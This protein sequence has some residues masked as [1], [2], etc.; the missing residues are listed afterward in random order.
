MTTEYDI[1]SAAKYLG[2]TTAYIRLLVRTKVLPSTRKPISEGS[3]VTKHT[4][5]QKQVDAIKNR[6]NRRILRTD[7]RRKYISFMREDEYLRVLNLLKENDLVEV[8]QLIK[9]A[10]RKPQPPT[11]G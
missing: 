3:K 10:T 11:D 6:P 4:F 7:G 2:Y 9:P 8:A 1:P 5:T